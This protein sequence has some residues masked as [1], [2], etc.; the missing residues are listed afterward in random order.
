MSF[1]FPEKKYAAK[2]DRK[3]Y[4]QYDFHEFHYKDSLTFQI[5]GFLTKISKT[6]SNWT[7]VVVGGESYEGRQILGLRIN[8]PSERD[9]PKNIVFVESG[10]F[11][12]SYGCGA[13]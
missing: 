6:Y 12:N 8:T 4:E 1:Y 13:V 2:L 11:F 5:N 7:Q 9:E 3:N 10:N